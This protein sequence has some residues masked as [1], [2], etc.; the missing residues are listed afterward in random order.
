MSTSF[1][2]PNQFETSRLEAIGDPPYLDS[3]D[4]RGRYSEGKS[5]RVVDDGNPTAWFLLVSPKRHRFT[6][7]F[8]AAT[9]TPIREVT[10]EDD[11]GSLFCRRIIDLFYPDGDPGRRVPYSEVFTVTQ[12]ISTDRIVT[13]TLASPLGDDEFREVTLDSDDGFRRAVP[14]FGEWAPLLAASTP[15]DL[16]RFGLDALDAVT[17]FAEDCV[18]ADRAGSN[19]EVVAL[20][21]WRVQSSV[22][23]IMRVVDAIVAGESESTAVPAWDRGAVRILP[24]AFQT[25]STSGRSADEEIRRMT[26]LANELADACEYRAGRGIALPLDEADNDSIRSYAEALRAAGVTEATFWDFGNDRAVVLVWQREGG[27]VA[28]SLH[29]VP[30]SWVSPRHLGATVD[31]IDVRWSPADLDAPDSLG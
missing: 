7:T 3:D 21:G 25:D 6:L 19:D 16:E 13:V 30:A 8:Y 23:D 24:L 2:Y 20:G 31:G 27:E 22:G 9:G 28:L 29:I 11:G 26:A 12:Q 1:R 10:W 4:A 15:P 14:E 18:P 5:L 17:A